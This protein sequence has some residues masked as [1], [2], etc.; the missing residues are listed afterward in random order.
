MAV[1]RI[2][3]AVK[4]RF[5]RLL[6]C[7]LL[8]CLAACATA[9]KAP[10]NN[11]LAAAPLPLES[12]VIS[13]PTSIDLGQLG[14]ELQKQLPRPF[15]S[16]SH[17]R[18]LPLR[19]SAMRTSVSLEPGVCSVTELN[20]L[21]RNSIRTVAADLMTPTEALV[22]QQ[23]FVRG[24]DLSMDGNQFSLTAQVDFTIATRLQSA[25]A[26]AGTV[27]CGEGR[28]R[29]RFELM[30]G[31]QVGWGAAGDV[32]LA[33]RPYYVR[34]LQPC[35]ITGFQFSAEN[36]LALP[37]LRDKL[38]ALMQQGVFGSLRQGS[39][40]AQLARA[41]PELSAP[42]EI[43]AGVWLLP[44][45]ERVAFAELVGTG[46]Y[47]NTSVLVHAYPELVKGARPVAPTP[48]LPVPERGLGSGDG[49]HMAIR[50]DLPLAEAEQLLRQRLT[51]LPGGGLRLESL[52]LYGNGD[53]AVLALGLGEPVRAEVFL[54]GRP[55]YDL[56]SNEVRLESLQPAADTRA[57]LARKAPA[58]LEEGFLAALQA[59]A[60][61]GFD[62]ALAGA[63]R[64]FR[65]LRVAAGR[66]MTWR[67]GIRRMQ[68]RALY[69][70]RDS[71]VAYVLV[72]G[73]LALE[74]RQK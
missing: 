4:F 16:A 25:Q 38:L 33:P 1:F 26:P 22:T 48:P 61:F 7:A 55:V 32:V 6:P 49:M 15:L 8:L 31:G 65:D 72:E 3:A 67:G 17:R 27:S 42:R 2:R 60:R 24:L 5:L 28:A 19:F 43:S 44:N 30:L 56:D 37:A 12:S 54:F 53:R 39:L 41:W 9:P 58:L 59:Q 18:T 70:T 46:R 13:I 63:L 52:R 57:F 45:P 11:P 36:L 74:A 69:F 29:P 64:E 71:L 68:P 35:N 34:W 23:L 62:P 66:G 47:I 10:P 40:Y 51:A 73:R 14:R 20:C 50:G 21:T